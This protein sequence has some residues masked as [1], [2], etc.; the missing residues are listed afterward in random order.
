[1]TPREP[2]GKKTKIQI[3][4]KIHL[5]GRDEFPSA[6]GLALAMWSVRTIM[7]K[8]NCIQS[9]E[10]GLIIRVQ[11]SA[12]LYPEGSLPRK[13]ISKYGMDSTKE[14]NSGLNPRASCCYCCTMICGVSVD[15]F[16]SANLVT[17]YTSIIVLMEVLRSGAAVRQSVKRVKG[18]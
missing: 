15:G 4:M 7:S 13:V 10:C 5:V 16:H 11:I 3:M 17:S 1:M 12:P 9:N 6:R 8:T 2:R 14:W 18:Q